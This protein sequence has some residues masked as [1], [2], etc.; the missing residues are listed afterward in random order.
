MGPFLVIRM[1]LNDIYDA[2]IVSAMAIGALIAFALAIPIA[3]E[4]ALWHLCS[5][6]NTSSTSCSCVVQKVASLP[7]TLMAY[8]IYAYNLG[9]PHILLGSNFDVNTSTDLKD[10]FQD[11]LQ[12][13]LFKV[14]A[15]CA[16]GGN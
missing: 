10:F 4:I 6:G 11:P 7:D 13:A 1:I 3:G 5:A 12:G 9:V 15:S 14:A 16:F 8:R 2:T